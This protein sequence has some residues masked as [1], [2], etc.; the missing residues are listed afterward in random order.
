MKLKF[1]AIFCCNFFAATSVLAGVMREDVA[2]QEY[3][4]FAEN[5]GKYAVGRENIEVFKTDGTSAGILNYPMPDF[6]AVVS[7][8]Y[9][10]L[11]S[12]SY[13]ASVQHNTGYKTVDFGNNAKYKTIYKLINRNEYDVRDFHLPRLNKVVTE[14][15][16]IPSVV[17]TELRENP[18]R[19]TWYARVGA[20]TQ[21]QVDAET[22]ELVQLAGAYSW[23]TGGTM[24]NPTFENW[25]LRWYNYSPD[26]PNVQPLDSASRGGDSGSPMLVYD[27]VDKVWKLAGVLTSGGNDGPYNLRSYILFVQDAFVE[28]VMAANVDPDVTDSSAEG[29]INW[30]PNA[31]TQGAKS[32]LWHGTDKTLPTDAT[33]EE[34]DATKDLRFNGEGG[35]LV[36]NQAVNHGAAKLQFSNNYQVK[37]AEGQNNSWVGGG[38]EVDADKTVLWQVNGLAGDVL[39]KIGDGTLHINATG[40]NSGGLNVG[41]GTVILD[42]QADA[43]GLKQAFSTLTLVSG[44]PVVVLADKDQINT[45]NIQFGY[46]GGTL[47]INGNGLTFAEI[48]HN[49]NGAKIVNR[50]LDKTGV[51]TLYGNGFNFP[52]HIGEQ[53]SGKLNL[54][55]YA[56]DSAYRA[57]LSGGADVETLA[58]KRGELILSGQ[59]TLHAGNV[60]YSDDWSEQS[61]LTNKTNVLSGA[62]LT[63]SDHAILDGTISVADNASLTLYAH[64]LL[65]GSLTLAGT[66]S[67][68]TADITER[69]SSVEGLSSMITADISGNGKLVKS[70]EGVLLAEGDITTAGDIE[71]EAGTLALNGNVAPSVNM[72]SGT[73]LAGSVTLQTVNASQGSTLYPGALYAETANYSTLS[74]ANLNTSGTVNLALNSAFN[75]NA[76]DKLLIAGDI[77]DGDSVMVSINSLSSWTDSDSNANGTADNTEGVSII[78]VG[79]NSSKDRF[80]LAGDYVASGAWAYGLYA[81]APGSAAESEREV[82]GS[83]SQY[84]DYRLQNVLLSEGSNSEPEA[85]AEETPIVTPETPA[86]EAPI[87]TPEAPAEEAP[88]VTPEA[89]AEETPIVTPEA[90]AEETP[91]V[92]PEAPAEAAPAATPEAPAEETPA[93]TPVE[94]EPPQPAKPTR[95]AVTP[96]VPAYI[97]LPSA[98]FRAEEQLAMLFKESALDS[99]K[100]GHSRFFLF[101]YRGDDNYQSGNSFMQYGYNYKSQYKGWMMGTTLA[102][103][104][105]DRQSLNVSGAWSKGD[106]SFKPSAADGVSQ[107][108][109]DS[110]ALNL[111]LSWHYEDYYLNLLSGYGWSEGTISTHLRGTAASPNVKQFFGEAEAGKYIQS[112]AH[113]F[114]PYAGY[115][116]QQMRIAN[117]TDVDRAQVSYQQQR[118]EAW[119]GGLA[120]D[121]TLPAGKL[122]TLR[123]GTDVNLAVR[124]NNQGKVVIGNGQSSNDFHTGNGGNSLNIKTEGWL[125]INKDI[126]L[127]TQVRHQRKLQQEGANDWLFAGGINIS[128]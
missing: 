111:M 98:L 78:Q 9:A 68:L 14:A 125:E 63:V 88:I 127:T 116:Q 45:K 97:S 4:D 26:D 65:S 38:I 87:V 117:F 112:G 43:N 2:V 91:I 122:G 35:T 55:Y 49:D 48:N 13:L 72:A 32:W 36:L 75:R 47:D 99:A 54:S 25:R 27:N 105:N 86:E 12:A 101:G 18:D 39:H 64:T 52:G 61:Y 108:N 77:N 8:G 128:F 62:A 118:R 50:N 93:A 15:A 109:V 119:I 73:V 24:T 115:R 33:N 59:Q 102:A 60:F 31:I 17:G 69:E 81:F 58:V 83:G 94:K 96:Q 28:Q 90:P 30:D 114:R 41:A 113:R 23:K 76:T 85:P 37:S 106:L 21:F 34:L 16:A 22:Q 84:W 6:G 66:D 92:T 70:G 89:P 29:I 44:R 56:S 103:W 110:N 121:Y 10:T 123:L 20:G 1:L 7:G 19:Y 40:A 80:K 57:T 104:H 126:A 67:V 5:L 42:Q 46:R 79:G 124:P 53:D 95:R 11:F 82:S 100:E 71:L 74:L 120:Y 3:R 107:G 51:V